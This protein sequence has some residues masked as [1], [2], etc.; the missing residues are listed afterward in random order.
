MR[1]K[2]SEH[3]RPFLWPYFICGGFIVLSGII[4]FGIPALKRRQERRR[5]LTKTEKDM[6]VVSYDDENAASKQQQQNI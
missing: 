6:G 5:R 4:L 2:L 1:D 3:A